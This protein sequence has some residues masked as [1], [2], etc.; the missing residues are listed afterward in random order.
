[1]PK[2]WKQVAAGYGLDIPDSQLDRIAPVLDALEAG[3][4]PLVA[5]IPLD[6]EPAVVFR[7]AENA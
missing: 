3:F 7:P 1:M 2:D 4:R 5:G 6:V